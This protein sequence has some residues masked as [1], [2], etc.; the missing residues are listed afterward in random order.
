M[1]KA[2][3]QHGQ[4]QQQPAAKQAKAASVESLQGA[5]T[6]QLEVMMNNSPR[7]IAQKKKFD[8]LFGVT[9]RATEEEP[10]QGKFEAAL[11]SLARPSGFVTQLAK[12][13]WDGSKWIS[14]NG[15]SSSTAPQPKLPGDFVGQ[16]F[17]DTT[18]TYTEASEES[19]AVLS[20]DELKQV[21]ML[22][23]NIMKKYPPDQYHYLGLGK[24][25]TPVMAFLQAYGE[26]VNPL[27]SATNMP[28][29]K[30]GHRM[31]GMSS[32]ERRVI[33]G[34]ELNEEQRNRLWEH[35][36]NFVPGPDE[37][38]GK[39]ILLI[40]LVQSGKSLVATQRH[41]EQYLK[42]RYHGSGVTGMYFGLLSAFS[43]FPSVPQVEALPLAIEEQQVGGQ[44]EVMDSLGLTAKAMMIPGKL[45]EE[46]SLA[47]RM[48]GEKYK[49]RAEFPDD[50]KISADSQPKT[51]DIR[52]DP[53][54]EF[55]KMKSEFLTFLQP[56]IRLIEGEK[57]T[58]LIEEKIDET[59][60]LLKIKIQ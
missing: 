56:T 47:A 4:T 33:S 51:K 46:N 43:C 19:T 16:V 2:D 40:D 11:T 14:D 10:L 57:S 17:D 35:F 59:E 20:E 31:S 34:N 44:K 6:A 60:Q 41:L 23:R 18:N 9:Q 21:G 8:S 58:E 30:F 26:R 36:D 54:G 5:H 13:T 45:S 42:E 27:V 39:S 52:K 37:L 32:A 48:G 53:R 7:Q 24:S 50:F 1:Q 25:P 3:P 38:E 55:A 22:A 15:P 28:L 49:P 12:H 29:S